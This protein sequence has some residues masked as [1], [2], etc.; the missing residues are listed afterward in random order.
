MIIFFFFFFGGGGEEG[1]F[2]GQKFKKNR[3]FIDSSRK[4]YTGYL[5]LP[6]G[7]CQVSLLVSIRTPEI[8]E[9]N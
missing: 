5:G 6:L 4:L 1:E 3:I 7:P 8:K 2:W 9:A